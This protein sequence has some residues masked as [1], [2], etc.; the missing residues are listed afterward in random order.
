MNNK[1]NFHLARATLDDVLRLAQI[2]DRAFANDSH[3]QFKEVHRSAE[4]ASFQTGM[5]EGLKQWMRVADRCTIIKAVDSRDGG[6]RIAGWITWGF[7]GVG[8]DP[9]P[10]PEET[11]GEP[12]ISDVKADLVP[13]TPDAAPPPVLGGKPKRK[14]RLA[15]L[16]RT[17][18][19]HL[20]AFQGRIMSV[21]GTTKCLYVIATTVDP[22]YQGQGVGSLLLRWGTAQAD[23]AG[24]FCWVHA[25]EAG[26]RVFGR[27]G[28]EELER[29]VVRLDE[30]VVGTEEEEEGE[31]GALAKIGEDKGRGGGEGEGVGE[32]KKEK[33]VWGEYTFR[34]MVRQPL[35]T[36]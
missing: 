27:H 15:E 29:L 19:G 4:D 9:M 2:A 32:G 10:P 17:T 22:A 31:K 18:S 7:R 11:I 6:N 14:A 24:V 30:W 20:A 34:Y 5:E 26:S 1:P 21:G 13:T 23:R 8:I 33:V 28:F 16:E 36:G 3:T 25:S 35:A 12:A